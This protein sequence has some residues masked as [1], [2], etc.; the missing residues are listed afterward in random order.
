MSTSTCTGRIHIDGPA[1]P[2]PGAGGFG[3]PSSAGFTIGRAAAFAGTTVATVRLYHQYGL[4]DEP[5]RDSSGRRRYGPAEL[6]R[7]VRVRTLAGAGVPLT[8]IADL[9]DY[10]ADIERVLGDRR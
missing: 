10:L 7:L 2:E 1:A 9:L 8:D 4:L 6:L 3:R 5:D